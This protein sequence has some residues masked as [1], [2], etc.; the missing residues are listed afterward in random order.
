MDHD[1]T[2]IFAISSDVF[3]VEAFWQQEIKLDSRKGFFFS[4]G[5]FNLDIQ[6]WSVEGCFTFG[7]KV[8]HAHFIKSCTKH[9]LGIFPHLIVIKVLMSILRVT[10]REAE[11]VFSQ[12]EVFINIDNQL[13]G[14]LEFFLDLFWSNE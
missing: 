2:V 14:T 7:F 3:E 12:V 9:G 11:A 1:W 4:K 13:K 6:F 8:V 10:K 5:S